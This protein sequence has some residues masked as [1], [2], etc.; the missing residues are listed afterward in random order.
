M[1]VFDKMAET[2]GDNEF[3]AWLSRVIDAKQEIVDFVASRR[4]GDAIGKFDSYLKGSFNLSLVVEF[5]DEGPKAVIRFPKPGHTATEFWKE[6]VRN[7]VNVLEFLARR[8]R[9]PYCKL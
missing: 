4:K 8:L 9:F 7:E 5:N 2:D 1:T 3:K 6:R